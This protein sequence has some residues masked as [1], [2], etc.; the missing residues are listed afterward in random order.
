MTFKSPKISLDLTGLTDIAPLGIA[1]QSSTSR[2]SRLDDAQRAVQ[3][4]SSDFAFH[5][6]ITP[7]TWWKLDLDRVYFP[8]LILI[9]NRRRSQFWHLAKNI[10]VSVSENGKD[11]KVLHEGEVYFGTIENGLPLMLPIT[12]C[13]LC[14]QLMARLASAI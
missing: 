4:V 9:S 12:D 11:W 6:D 1:T 13:R 3:D 2:W 7:D 14:F 5:T 8:K 10:S